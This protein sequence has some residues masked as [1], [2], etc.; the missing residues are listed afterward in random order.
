MDTLYNNW[1]TITSRYSSDEQLSQTLYTNLVERYNE[2]GRH[3][4]NLTHVQT[5]LYDIGEYYGGAIPDELFFAVWFHDAIYNTIIGNNEARSADLAVEQL[6]KLEVPANIIARVKD[7]IL[8]TADHAAADAYDEATKVFLDADLKILGA[9]AEV[10]EQYTQQVRRE[11]H[12]IPDMLF[13]PGRRKF[14]ERTLALPGI[15]RTEY[16]ESRYEAQAR[17]NLANEVKQ[18]S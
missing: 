13:K 8:K 10:Y 14:V 18:L 7:L 1:N 3:Y 5:L 15:F 4:H 6:E 9:P 17:I 16:F 2:S 11:Y 12:L